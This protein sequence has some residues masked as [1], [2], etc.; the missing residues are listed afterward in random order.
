MQLLK[1]MAQALIP[2]SIAYTIIKKDLPITP[3]PI[4]FDLG[5][6][7]MGCYC[8]EQLSK[9]YQPLENTLILTGLFALRTGVIYALDTYKP[10]HTKKHKQKRMIP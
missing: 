2:G 5:P 8:A 9:N 1:N 3:F 4:A 10:H 7:V 6:Y